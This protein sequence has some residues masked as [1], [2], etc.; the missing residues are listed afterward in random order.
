MNRASGLRSAHRTEEGKGER[1]SLEGCPK[2][3]PQQMAGS[4][5]ALTRF[6]DDVDPGMIHLIFKC[7]CFGPIALH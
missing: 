4:G 6:A 5:F 7:S 1:D 2:T 3:L